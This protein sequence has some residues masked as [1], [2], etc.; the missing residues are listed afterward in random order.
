M[1]FVENWNILQFTGCKPLTF[2]SSRNNKFLSRSED[3]IMYIA[4]SDQN[5]KKIV[6]DNLF[7]PSERL[8]YS[9]ES[10]F[11]ELQKSGLSKQKA[12]AVLK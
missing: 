10:I 2:V 11:F 8:I 6:L 4:L 1:V 7:T 9:Y 5:F 3:P 12:I